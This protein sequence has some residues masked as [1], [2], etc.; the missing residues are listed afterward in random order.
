MGNTKGSRRRFGAVRQYRS[1]RWT[2]SYP[3]PS[4]LVRRAPITFATK[5]DAEVWLS[6]VE[7][8]LTRG[9]WQDPDAGAVNFETYAV[10][11]VAERGLSATT[12]ELYRRLL[13]LHILPTFGAW[14]LDEIT[15]PRVRTWRAERLVETGAATTVA[16]AYR[17]LKAILET[18]TDDELIRRNPCRIR[19]AGKESAPER[20][21]A[22]VAQV[23]ALADALGPRWRLM[24]YLG[25]YGPLRPEEQAELRRRDVDLDTMTIRV[26]M[27]APELTTGRRVLGDTKSEAGRRLIVLPS[28]LRTDLRRHLDWYAEKGPDGLLFVGEK[29]K[30]FRRST[31]GRKWR[32]AREVV[33]VPDGFRFYDLR[34]TGHTMATRSGAT[35]KDTM[36]RAGQS[37]ERA[38]LIYQHS[39]LSRQQEIAT[40]LDALVRTERERAKEGDAG[41]SGADL[42]Q[43]A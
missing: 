34:H 37:S 5:S 29:G 9:D 18:A 10:Q 19:G 32:R 30:P 20:Q 24:V 39:D 16:K 40:G 14:D 2:A 41:P 11:W 27:A 4:G 23:D 21:V 38:A 7:A 35:L 25:A 36:V 8:D 26:R 15:P 13:R 17:L 22:T 42:V 3:D 28:F 6:Q 1:G 12:A 31:F 33:G 43:D